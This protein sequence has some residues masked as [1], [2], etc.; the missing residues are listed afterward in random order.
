MCKRRSPTSEIKY[1]F[2][3]LYLL[4][5]CVNMRRKY[6]PEVVTWKDALKSSFRRMYPH[7][8][9]MDCRVEPLVDR[10]L[11]VNS[12]YNILGGSQKEQV[13]RSVLH[14]TDVFMYSGREPRKSFMQARALQVISGILTVTATSILGYFIYLSNSGIPIP[15]EAFVWPSAA[16]AFFS[17]GL[18]AGHVSAKTSRRQLW[19]VANEYSSKFPSI[20]SNAIRGSNPSRGRILDFQILDNPKPPSKQ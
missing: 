10:L 9:K 16:A 12:S 3:S 15:A 17:L 5:I 8:G 11:S 7:S 2:K 1:L 20:L 18:L 4:L 19:D 6:G 14:A 13:R